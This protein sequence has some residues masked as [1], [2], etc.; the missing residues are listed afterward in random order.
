MK[1]LISEA[2]YLLFI[3]LICLMFFFGYKFYNYRYVDNL[4][5][6]KVVTNDN[7]KYDKE[8]MQAKTM[9]KLLIPNADI[10]L[11]I[12]DDD[13]KDSQTVGAG[14]YFA[15][16]NVFAL[17]SSK[18]FK[19]RSLFDNL[20]SIRVNDRFY[21][22]DS[23][24]KFSEYTVFDIIDIYDVDVFDA[25]NK[26]ATAKADTAEYIV[27]CTDEL[28]VVG[29]ESGYVKSVPSGKLKLTKYEKIYLSGVILPLL[30]MLLIM[31]YSK[32]NLLSKDK[33]NIEKFREN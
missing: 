32:R 4:D 14:I 10:D 20:N 2:K 25:V 18:G 15:D 31:V 33:V 3:L 26:I 16:N 19:D 6:S 27:L 7:S 1:R 13:S 24:G 11:P 5:K 28:M 22:K 8:Q 12:Y 29:R 9:G 30:L 23:S 21:I 17:I